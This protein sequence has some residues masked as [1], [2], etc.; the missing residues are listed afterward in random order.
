MRR[1]TWLTLRPWLFL[2]SSGELLVTILVAAVAIPWACY[3]SKNAWRRTPRS[4]TGA[5]T[6][7]ELVSAYRLAHTRKDPDLMRDLDFSEAQ[8]GVQGSRLVS[9]RKSLEALFELDL[10]EARVIEIPERPNVTRD[11]GYFSRETDGSVKWFGLGGPTNEYNRGKLVLVGRRANHDRIAVDLGLIIRRY[12]ERVYFDINYH[13]LSDATNV[14]ESNKEPK[15][16]PIPLGLERRIA[17]GL[18]LETRGS[19]VDRILGNVQEP[20]PGD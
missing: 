19:E 18:Y 9:R 3:D 17:D 5:A 15:Y 13:V 6:V 8:H 2:L 12:E 1:P 20:A 11:V 14:I 4:G 10:E 16:L 7:E